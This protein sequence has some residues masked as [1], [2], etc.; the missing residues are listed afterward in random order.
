MKYFLIKTDEKNKIPYNINKNRGIDIRLLTREMA[1]KIPFLN[2]VRMDFPKEGFLPDILSSP[3][4]L[5]T[6]ICMEVVS[7]YDP[8]IPFKVV[9]AVDKKRGVNK[10]YF[11]PILEEI[12][13]MSQQTQ[14]H[15]MGK[16]VIH[17]V[18]DE[19][20]VGAKAVF[21]AKGWDEPGMIARLDVVESI[22]RREAKGM[23]MEEIEQEEKE[24]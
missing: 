8:D 7:M 5:L 22:L 14:F 21:K 19:E 9:K 16:R 13:C 12:D 20:K 18:L 6:N 10:T 3:C 1:H 17:F 11:L 2:V 23:M 4:I 15:V 24:E